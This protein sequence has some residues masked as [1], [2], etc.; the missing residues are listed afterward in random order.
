MSGYPK[1]YAEHY[2]DKT[3]GGLNPTNTDLTYA[4][5]FDVTDWT[6]DKVD[7]LGEFGHQWPIR[8]YTRSIESPKLT[9]DIVGLSPGFSLSLEGGNV[10]FCTLATQFPPGKTCQLRDVT[11]AALC[12]NIVFTDACP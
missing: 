6:S 8:W 10:K 4:F 3:L 5:N 2:V 9:G 7:N 11:T 12:G 1:H